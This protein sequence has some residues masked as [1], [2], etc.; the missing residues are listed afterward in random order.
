[1]QY[2]SLKSTRR[3]KIKVCALVSARQAIGSRYLVSAWLNNCE[4]VCT[5]SRLPRA[6]RS[7]SLFCARHYDKVSLVDM[8]TGE[9]L[10]SFGYEERN[11]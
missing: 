11:D 8:E 9:V 1:M 3:D 10:N 5:F 7:F 6:E 2:Y 4:S